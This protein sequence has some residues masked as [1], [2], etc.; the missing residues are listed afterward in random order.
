MPLMPR[1]KSKG[2]KVAYAI[3]G[4]PSNMV[5]VRKTKLERDVDLR[6]NYEDS[7]LSR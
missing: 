1:M 5:K 3:L 6:L 4:V 7:R 2:K